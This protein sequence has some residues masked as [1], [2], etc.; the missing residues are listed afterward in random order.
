MKSVNKFF[1]ALGIAGSVLYACH[2]PDV[3]KSNPFPTY[4]ADTSSTVIYNNV[5]KLS[6]NDLQNIDSVTS[7]K[8]YFL[9]KTNYSKGDIL[10]SGI[11]NKTPGGL[12][13]KVELVSEDGK[14]IT[15]GRASLE[16]VFEKGEIKY[17][18]KLSPSDLEKNSKLKV[19]GPIYDFEY[20][21]PKTVIYDLDGDLQTENDQ[22]WLKGKVLF[23]SDYDVD[24]KFNKGTKYINFSTNFEEQAELEVGGILDKNISKQ[25]ELYKQSFTPIVIPNPAGVP[26]VLRPLIE[27]DA[28]VEGE[29][30]GE[31][32]SKVSLNQKTKAG[33][34]YQSGKWS[35]TKSN[36]NS[37]DFSGIKAGLEGKL[38]T[39]VKP[40]LEFVVNELIGPY[41]DME[42]YLRLE[43][44]TDKNPWWSLYGGIGAD[45]GIDPRVFSLVMKEQNKRIFE[46]EKILAQSKGK[47][48]SDSHTI[49][50]SNNDGTCES[51]I[52]F[53]GYDLAKFSMG[54]IYRLN[55]NI[56]V[57]K[58]KFE[59]DEFSIYLKDTST[60][61]S[62]LEI[63]LGERDIY[64]NS[65]ETRFLKEIKTSD[66]KSPGW[67][68]FKLDKPFETNTNKVYFLIS[69]KDYPNKGDET[70]GWK[71]GLDSNNK[72]NS[73]IEHWGITEGGYIITVHDKIKGEAMV[74]V[75]GKEI[76]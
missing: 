61:S 1:A 41:A 19:S 2:K 16:E 53:P 66:F 22:L 70:H 44:D 24:A 29:V 36:Q 5:I 4:P 34:T 25:I 57:P 17:H 7:D 37:F 45:I 31:V 56:D 26:V 62:P 27:I 52:Y 55:A 71:I 47:P 48:P 59:V 28:G 50:F 51:E 8:I 32:H 54:E 18:N 11:S 43:V 9:N 23:S 67:K 14:S 73:K 65:E 69:D 20:D 63:K 10:I 49:E 33:I 60:I 13:K 15:T 21:I 6:S 39:Y 42:G 68:T 30:Y 12:L 64:S 3:P 58:N 38:K 72:G 75:K 46:Y 40:K 76:K 74:K 35:T